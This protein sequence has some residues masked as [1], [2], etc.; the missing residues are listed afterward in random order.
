MG[1]HEQHGRDR[2][3]HTERRPIA[4]V[5]TKSSARLTTGKW[6]DIVAVSGDPLQGY[7]EHAESRVR[8]EERRDLQQ[9]K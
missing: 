7:R 2:R 1:R 5:G 8:D 4:W 3:R 6:A 9:Q